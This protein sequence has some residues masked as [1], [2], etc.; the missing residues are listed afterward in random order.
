[1]APLAHEPLRNHT[2]WR[3]GGPADFL[4]EPS[5]WEQAA[6]VLQYTHAHNIPAVVIG[7]GSN[8]LFDD[9]GL[10]GVVIKV[11]RQLSQLTIAGTIVRAQSGISA[12]RLARAVG[13]AGLGGLEHIVGIPGTLGGLVFMNGGSLR[14]AI[15]DAIVQ[16][17]TMDRQ[18]NV[19]TL[20]RE[21][22]RFAYRQSRFQKESCVIMEAT[23]ALVPGQPD[24]I[25]AEMRAI[26]RERRQKF[27]M[28]LPN[29]GSVFK[30]DPQACAVFGPPG[31]IIESAGLK[32]TSVGDA[33]VSERHANFIVNRGNARAADVLSLIDLVRERVVH[34]T[35]L[36]LECEVQ[37]VEAAG[38]VTAP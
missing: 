29:C 30:N 35:G 23:M 22:C 24:T 37:F 2:T 25:A 36:T 7:K 27:P 17:R 13:L 32:G 8:L 18:G 16:V 15:G 26:L 28:T 21:E 12:P 20:G 33:A 9:H 10:R 38:M 6:L 5:S 3:I 1:M 11:G 14:R 19:R 31:K 4:V 34:Q